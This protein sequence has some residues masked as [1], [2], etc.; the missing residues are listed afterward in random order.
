MLQ[1]AI[2]DNVERPSFQT[3]LGECYIEMKRYDEAERAL[4]A[5]L[6]EKPD[7]PMA[8]YDLGLVREARGEPDAIAEYEAEIA[9]NPTVYQAHFNLAKLLAAAGRKADAAAH[10]QRAVDANPK[11][12]SGYLYLAKARLDAGDLDGAEAAAVA[13]MKLQPDAEIA[14]L[15]HYVLADVYA[16]RGRLKDAEREE[17]A[18]RKLER[19]RAS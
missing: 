16:R 12:A 19:R 10:F 1:R 8:H 7:A 3:K 6:K 5:A 17:A 2:A 15:G 9:R 18:G 13:G 11:F 4:A 14:P